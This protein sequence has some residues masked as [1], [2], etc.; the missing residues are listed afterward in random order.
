MFSL[1]KKMHIHNRLRRTLP[2]IRYLLKFKNN[3]VRVNELA[4]FPPFVI[5]DIIDA[6]YNILRGNCKLTCK[7]RNIIMYNKA[8]LSN[9][10]SHERKFIKKRAQQQIY[11]QKGGFIGAIL[12]VIASILGGLVAQA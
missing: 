7:H 10:M 8:P 2:Y 4:T 12:P 1:K 3:R 9:L 11:K 6:L 5:N